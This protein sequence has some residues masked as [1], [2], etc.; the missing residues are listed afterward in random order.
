MNDL[1]FAVVKIIL[2]LYVAL[3]GWEDIRKRF[4]P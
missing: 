2:V 3:A 4:N 1:A